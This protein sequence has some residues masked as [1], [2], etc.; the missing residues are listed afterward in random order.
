[1]IKHRSEVKAY[2]ANIKSKWSRHAVRVAYWELGDVSIGVQSLEPVNEAGENTAPPDQLRP[3]YGWYAGC[4]NVSRPIGRPAIISGHVAGL[5]QVKSSLVGQRRVGAYAPKGDDTKRNQSAKVTR[6]RT[7]GAPLA[8][9]LLAPCHNNSWSQPRST[10]YDGSIRNTGDWC[11]VR[12][13]HNIGRNSRHFP[14]RYPY[15]HLGLGYHN[16]A[17]IASSVLVVDIIIIG[18]L[19]NG[20][21]QGP[22][23]S[24]PIPSRGALLLLSA[25]L[26]CP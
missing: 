13:G 21:V 9:P 1:M 26:L 15:C 16:H 11:L 12:S 23:V 18:I 19:P 20:T 6:V 24:H 3:C 17:P 2:R 7:C 4:G 14:R 22:S 10:Q 5:V 8:S 25:L